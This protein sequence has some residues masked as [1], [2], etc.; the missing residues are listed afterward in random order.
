MK[1]SRIFHVAARFLNEDRGGRG[2][3]SC[4]HDHGSRNMERCFLS[5]IDFSY[6]FSGLSFGKTGS[7][8]VDYE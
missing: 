1:I 7:L 6:F 2:G 4:Q 8:E 5:P 3:E